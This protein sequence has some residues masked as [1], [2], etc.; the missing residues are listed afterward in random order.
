MCG[1]D[2][3]GITSIYSAG[4]DIVSKAVQFPEENDGV[5][6]WPDCDN[7]L[8][9]EYA[10]GSQV[11]YEEVISKL[12]NTS[13]VTGNQHTN[14]VPR[15]YRPQSMWEASYHS[16]WYRASINHVDGTCR[17]GDSWFFA[18]QMPCSW[19]RRRSLP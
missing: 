18:D 2:P 1:T 12:L 13:T 4:M 9:Y 17:N 11:S 7:P 10:P 19:Y 8:G 6:G 5:V 3:F 14:Y 15:V 16:A